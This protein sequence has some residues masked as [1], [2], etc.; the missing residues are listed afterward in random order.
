MDFAGNDLDFLVRNAISNSVVL[1]LGAGFS[2]DA[3]NSQGNNIPVG[4]QFS[5]VLW[6]FLGYAETYDGTALPTMYEAALRR[7]HTDLQRLLD[8][9]FRCAAIPDWYSIVHRIFWMRIYT[10]NVDD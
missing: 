6:K 1:Y 8:E 9:N 3:K 5:E 10:T 4:N 2:V 7:K